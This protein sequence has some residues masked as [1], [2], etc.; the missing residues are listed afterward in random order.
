MAG[1]DLQSLRSAGRALCRGVLIGRKEPVSILS[2]YTYFNN[3]PPS[4]QRNVEGLLSAL[5]HRKETLLTVLYVLG[6]I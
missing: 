5:L 1:R 2:A 4:R 3:P 6:R